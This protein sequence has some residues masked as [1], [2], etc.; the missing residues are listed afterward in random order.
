MDGS[1]IAVL[2]SIA[3]VLIPRA[4]AGDEAAI[5]RVLSVLELRLKYKRQRRVEEDI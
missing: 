4:Q 3:A 2:D 1:E 5:D